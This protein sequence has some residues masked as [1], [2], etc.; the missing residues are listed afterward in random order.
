M[1]KNRKPLTPH[2]RL[3][4]MYVM[5]FVLTLVFGVCNIIYMVCQ[6]DATVHSVSFC[7]LQYVAMLLILVAPIVLRRYFMLRVPLALTVAIAVF[8]FVAMVFGDGLNFYGKYPWWDSFLHLLSGGVLAVLGLWLLHIILGDNGNAVMANKYFLA[9]YLLIFGLALGTM[10]EIM[11]YTYD[12][13]FGTNTQ[14]FM[15]T[16]TSSLPGPDDIP[17]SGHEALRDTMTDLILDLV[18]S[19]LVAI[20]VLF[21]HSKLIQPNEE[22]QKDKESLSDSA[23]SRREE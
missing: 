14:Q 3:K 5:M 23:T 6:P 22:S 4:R 1:T 11:E 13:L 2:D 15:L 17:A 12:D 19:L 9:F 21:R 18:G 10:W 7:A 20:Y 16:T 8:A